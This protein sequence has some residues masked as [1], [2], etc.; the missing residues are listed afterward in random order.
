MITILDGVTI[1][2]SG[3]TVMAKGPN[4]QVEKTFTPLVSIKLD[5]SQ[6]SVE[7][8]K[9]YATTVE[10]CIS[11]MMQGVSDGFKKELKVIYAHFP[12]S[13]EVKGKDILIKNFQGEK[14][15]RT[16]LVAGDT[17]VA[18]KGQLISVSGPDK[19]AVGQTAANLK[20]ATK[21][22]DKDDRIFQDGI[23]EVEQ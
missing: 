2:I 1:E 20:Q 5:N 21:I 18:V 7:G 6:V 10:N 12:I 19:E 16:A 15:P 22:K 14:Q 23:Y 11:N 17:K 8:E 9:S 3:N 4:G 13:L